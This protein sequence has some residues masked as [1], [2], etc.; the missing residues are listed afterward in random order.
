MISVPAGGVLTSI[1]V[2]RD[3]PLNLRFHEKNDPTDVSKVDRNEH[4][5]VYLENDF[6]ITLEF[7]SKPNRSCLSGSLHFSS[8]WSAHVTSPSD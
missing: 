7:L 2:F 4:K 3:S 5:K 6:T 8:D 1:S